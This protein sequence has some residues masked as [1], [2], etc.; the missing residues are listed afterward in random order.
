[1]TRACQCL[2]TRELP[3]PSLE[4]LSQA[5]PPDMIETISVPCYS[6]S[7]STFITSW[8]S[9]SGH[10]VKNEITPARNPQKLPSK[11]VWNRTS[12]ISNVSSGGET[13]TTTRLF[14][15]LAR[16]MS[17]AIAESIFPLQHGGDQTL[18]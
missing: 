16:T 13:T 2:V 4:Y 10:H 18:H 11:V 17:R 3:F 9:I 7:L 8:G 1:M 12:T 14:Y 6:Q 15:T 5:L